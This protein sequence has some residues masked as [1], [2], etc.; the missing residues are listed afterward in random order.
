MPVISATQKVDFRRI[1]VLGQSR[2]EV[3]ETPIYMNV[4]ETYE[5]IY[6]H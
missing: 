5:Y 2:Q 4:Y 3:S 6:E 1:R